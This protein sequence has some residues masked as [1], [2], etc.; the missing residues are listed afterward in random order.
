MRASAALILLLPLALGCV[1][2]ARGGLYPADRDAV[3]VAYFTNDTFYRDVEFQLTEQVVAE[4]L[5]RPGLHLT[6]REQAE[7][8][9][10]GRIVYVKQAVLSEDP[11][12]TP[13]FR[14]TSIAIE[15]QLLDAFSGDVLKTRRFS[16]SGDFVPRLSE[17]VESARLDVFRLLARDVVRV[18]EAEF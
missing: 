6:S 1:S 5:S 16:Q 14:S 11:D 3:F 9:I 12:R 8:L 2:L 18:L 17:S 10:E 15:I 7:V 4:I 13:T